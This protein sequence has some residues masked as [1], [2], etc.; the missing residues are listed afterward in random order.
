MCQLGT[1]FSGKAVPKPSVKP[2]CAL[3]GFRKGGT[4]LGVRQF[5]CRFL[6]SALFQDREPPG[7][8]RNSMALHQFRLFYWATVRQTNYARLRR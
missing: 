7:L 8:G 4:V 2:V 6:I 5:L 3:C 1:P